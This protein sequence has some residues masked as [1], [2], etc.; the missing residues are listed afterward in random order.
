[1]KETTVATKH[2]E[3]EVNLWKWYDSAP[4]DPA[5]PYGDSSWK[6][7]SV[8]NSGSGVAFFWQK[9]CAPP[10]KDAPVQQEGAG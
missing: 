4:P 6:L 10:K 9:E 3:Q 5:P 1:V 2:Y 8:I 7:V